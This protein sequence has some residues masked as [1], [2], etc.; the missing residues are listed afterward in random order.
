MKKNVIIRAALMAAITLGLAAACA[1]EEKVSEEKPVPGE[2]VVN[3]SVINASIPDEF[4]KVALDDAGVGNGLALSWEEGDKLTV[5]G[6]TTEQFTLAS[7]AGEVTA[8]FSGNPVL[9]DSFTILYPGDVYDTVEEINARS[10]AAQIQDGNA[11]TSHLEWNAK[12]AGVADYSTLKFYDNANLVQNGALKFRLQ[13]PTEFTKVY[14]VALKAPSAIFYATNSS[15]V[16]TDEL[17]LTLKTGSSDGITLGVDKVLTAFMMVSWQQTVIPADTDLTIEVWGDQESPWT[18]VKSVG[19]GGFT[20]AGGKVTTVTLNKNNWD[21]PLFWAGDGTENDPFQ[22]KTLANLKNIKLARTEDSMVYFKLIDDIDM[23]SVP[24]TGDD[25]WG[26][27]NGSVSNAEKYPVYFDGNNHTI[28]NFS[29]TRSGASF[30]GSLQNSTVKDLV[31]ENATVANASSGDG[32]SCAVIAYNTVNCTIQ[33]VD[34][35]TASITSLITISDNSKGTGGLV[36]RMLDGTIEDCDITDLTVSSAS[37]RA[38]GLAGVVPGDSQPSRSIENCTITGFTISGTEHVGGIV[39]RI[40]A[41]SGTTISGCTVTQGSSPWAGISGSSSSVGG[42][43]GESGGAVNLTDNA[44]I[45]NVTGTD[46]VGGIIG[47]GS[48]TTVINN[49]DVTGNVTGTAEAADGNVGTGGIAGNITGSSSS[50]TNGCSVNGT[51]SGG[52]RVGGI[53][54]RTGVA[55]ISISGANV[56]GKVSGNTHVGGIVGR[57]HNTGF[58]ASWNTVDATIEGVTYVGGIAGTLATGATISGNKV[59]GLIMYTVYGNDDAHSGFGGLVGNAQGTASMTLSRNLVT[60]NVRGCRN[61]GGLVGQIA[62]TTSAVTISECAYEGPSVSGYTESDRWNYSVNGTGRVG[63]LVGYCPGSGAHT[64]SNCYASGDLCVNNGWS[65]G[66]VG[67]APTGAKLALSNSFSTVDIT[68]TGGNVLGGII[69]GIGYGGLENAT[70]QTET[71]N[72]SVEKCISWGSVALASS[73]NGYGAVLANGSWKATLTDNYRK[74][75]MSVT[76]GGVAKT[77]SNDPNTSSSSLNTKYTHDGIEAGASDT[78]S[79]VATALGWST[80]IWKLDNGDGFPT[81]KNLP[82]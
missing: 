66:L 29:L 23:S 56:S 2:E 42:I 48:G 46:K 28:S 72:V 17:K 52:Y 31:F 26:M 13:L 45:A 5:I 7:G 70:L 22:I 21:E 36:G 25:Q 16:L 67:W 60:A 78:I 1:K 81:L 74:N 34:V 44:V 63:A 3:P 10:Y 62:V 9:G 43:L 76:K 55:N 15:D 47:L 35:N 58:G 20:I 33:N 51:I 61:T 4:T 71:C 8:T 77:M 30:F 39:G 38:G 6:T 27:F 11:G 14:S 57:Q 50:I 49:C 18:K 82:E 79:S 40:S 32:N 73:Q 68:N 69:G 75:G 80:T 37:T 53:L 24:A 64:I 59:A 41:S 65:G 19:E 54:G 12:I